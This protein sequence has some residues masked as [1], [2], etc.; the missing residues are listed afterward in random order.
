MRGLTSEFF[1]PEDGLGVLRARRFCT[2]DDGTGHA[3]PVVNECLES[4]LAVPVEYAQ[5][6]LGGTS[7]RER[8]RILRQRRS[9]SV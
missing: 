1:H 3:C 6:V 2:G 9:V 4:A 5:G 7:Q 8:V